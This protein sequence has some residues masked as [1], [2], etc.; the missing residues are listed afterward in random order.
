MSKFSDALKDL[1]K[2][3]DEP[4]KEGTA[5]GR[6]I[7]H[8]VGLGPVGSALVGTGD[9]V[10]AGALKIVLPKGSDPADA[11]EHVAKALDATRQ[12]LTDYGTA[13]VL[14]VIHAAIAA[15]DLPFLE[16]ENEA[17]TKDGLY[18]ALRGLV[19]QAQAE[20]HPTHP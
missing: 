18:N 1:I 7:E 9:H 20:L 16:G 12:D 15:P 8:S 4:G 2:Q 6:L 10:T 14:R 19:L 5:L 13:L 11:T 3:T 17:I